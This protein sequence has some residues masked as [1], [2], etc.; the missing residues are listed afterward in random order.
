MTP[1]MPIGGVMT[2]P[3]RQ[4]SAI[5]GHLEQVD[6]LRPAEELQVYEDVLAQLTELL[7]APEDPG[8]GAA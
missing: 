5:L 1:L 3:E 4:T 6:Q 8:P 2:E 7:N